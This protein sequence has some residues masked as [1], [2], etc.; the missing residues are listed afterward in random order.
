MELQEL[1]QAIYSPNKIIQ[2]DLFSE[3]NLLL[4]SFALPGYDCLDDFLL[5]DVVSRIEIVSLNKL[6]IT[7]DTSHN[8]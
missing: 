2:I 3:N 6:N 5:D 7:I 8:N 4:I 1:L